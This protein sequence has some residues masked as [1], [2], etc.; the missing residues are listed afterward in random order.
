LE[1]AGL[2]GTLTT[3]DPFT[4]FGRTN[5]AFAAIPVVNQLLTNV[6]ALSEVLLYCIVAG[7]ILAAD[8]INDALV[9]TLAGSSV[10]VNKYANRAIHCQLC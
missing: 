2:N 7:K 8:I 1:V 4:E 6:T 5:D 3:A 9:P 10:R